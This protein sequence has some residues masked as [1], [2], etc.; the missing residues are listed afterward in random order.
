MNTMRNTTVGLWYV[1]L[2]YGQRAVALTDV[3]ATKLGEALPPG[4]YEVTADGLGVTVRSRRMPRSVTATPAIMLA[5]PGAVDNKLRRVG[6]VTAELAREFAAP[7]AAKS[8][9]DVDADA[10]V[11]WWGDGSGRTDT[12]IRI[13]RAEI[14]I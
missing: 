7:E 1:M 13:A 12:R 3:L 6:L 4:E 9:A 8:G 11:V 2:R 10:M 5:T 14:R